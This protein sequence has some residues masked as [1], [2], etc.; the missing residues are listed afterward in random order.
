M[1]RALH[2][3]F[4]FIYIRLWFESAPLF[5]LARESSY[6]FCEFAAFIWWY[7]VVNLGREEPR[8]LRIWS[9]ILINVTLGDLSIESSFF[10]VSSIRS[11]SKWT[12]PS[13]AHS[14][15]GQTQALLTRP[16]PSWCLSI[17]FICAGFKCEVR[18]NLPR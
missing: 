8:S 17:G 4:A 14:L 16:I 11:P 18:H 3:P 15:S 1:D 10:L 12:I 2:P 6:L 5:S 13:W 7:V 9:T